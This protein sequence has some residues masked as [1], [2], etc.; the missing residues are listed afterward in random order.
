MPAE[1]TIAESP[2]ETT[3]AQ[4][5]PLTE[6]Q[7]KAATKA[8]EA[9]LPSQSWE[10]AVYSKKGCTGDYYLLRGYNKQR[11][12]R[13]DTDGCV[14]LTGNTNTDIT[15]ASTSCRWW[16]DEGLSWTTCSESTLKDPKSW[17]ITSG[18]CTAYSDRKCKSEAGRIYGPWLGCQN[19]R[20]A[21][22]TP[23]TFRSL[24]CAAI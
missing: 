23:K 9:P 8:I 22:L 5:E 6:T 10:I 15:Q 3:V 1:A 16:K 21:P 17:V 14:D 4:P 24:V 19:S 2:K 12:D 7:K 20:G 11:K 13:Y 18:D